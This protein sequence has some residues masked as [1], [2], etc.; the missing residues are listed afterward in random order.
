MKFD[1]GVAKQPHTRKRCCQPIRKRAI[2][3]RG[4]IG[5]MQLT[6]AAKRMKVNHELDTASS[7]S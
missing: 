2:R 3:K 4:K 6:N 1:T 5:K 7:S